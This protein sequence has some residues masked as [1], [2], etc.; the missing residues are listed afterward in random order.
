MK[1]TIFTEHPV[2]ESSSVPVNHVM[3]WRDVQLSGEG[4][5]VGPG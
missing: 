5:E 1:N 4:G 2:F 3:V